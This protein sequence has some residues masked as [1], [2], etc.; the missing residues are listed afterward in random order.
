MDIPIQCNSGKAK[1][2][3]FWK[4]YLYYTN[5]NFTKLK[6]LNSLDK[7]KAFIKLTGYTLS[8]P[9]SYI[10]LIYLNH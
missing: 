6:C 2:I 7:V 10:L 9:I 5:I 8:Y 3:F 1:C 4:Y